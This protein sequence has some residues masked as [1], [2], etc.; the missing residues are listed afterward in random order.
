MTAPLPDGLRDR[1]LAAARG[2]RAAGR[3]V[4]DVPVIA[5][6]EAFSRSADAFLGL[7]AA[8][9]DDAWRTPVLRDLD[10][11]GLVGHLTGVED[12]VQRA[13]AGD[14]EVAGAD[15]VASTQPAAERQAGRSP[16]ATRREWR[17]A[18]DR[19]LAVVTG[20]DLTALAPMHGMRLPLGALLVVRAFELWIH[21]NDIRGVVGLPP[22]VPDPATLRLMTELAVGCCRTGWPSSPP[23][24]APGG[25]APRADRPRRRHVG[26]RSSVGATAGAPVPEVG[27]VADAVAFCRLVADRIGPAELRADVTRGGRARGRRLRR[28]GRARA[29]LTGAGGRLLTAQAPPQRGRVGFQFSISSVA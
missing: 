10:V 27:I 16:E 19:T 8:L 9:S 20:A 21:E 24:R 15:H 23:A 17:T 28:R 22:S 3:P 26:R 11:Q 5:P 29:R 12:D 2:A 4:P 18:A 14:P 7:L 6:P 13:I 1:V 25:R